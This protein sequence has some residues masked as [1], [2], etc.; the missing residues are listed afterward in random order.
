MSIEYTE[1]TYGFRYGAAEITRL[2]SDDKKGWVTLQLK[3]PK[4][5]IQIYITKTGKVRINNNDGEFKAPT[6][7]AKQ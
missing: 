4:E 1:L 7:K 6:K 2:F 3:T 5:D